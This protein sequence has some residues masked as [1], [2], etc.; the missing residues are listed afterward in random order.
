MCRLT[1]ATI[2]QDAATGVMSVTSV[3]DAVRVRDFLDVV[4]REIV[5]FADMR[6]FP[7][8]NQITAHHCMRPSALSRS[9]ALRSRTP[10]DRAGTARLLERVAEREG[11]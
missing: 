6:T 9:S 1:D 3:P 4:H 2:G 10:G 5:G 7:T 11:D 8:L